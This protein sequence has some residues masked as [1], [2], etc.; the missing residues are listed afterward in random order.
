MQYLTDTPDGAWAEFL[1]HEEIRDPVDLQGVRRA[2]WAIDLAEPPTIPPALEP[3]IALG[4]PETY[5]AC[6]EAAAALRGAGEPGLVAPSAAL[7]EGAARGWRVEHGLQEAAPRD[8]H[9]F[10]LF[11]ARPEATGWLAAVGRPGEDVL[12]RVRH[13]TL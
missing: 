8:G 3:H 6:Q 11:G 4:N 7:F 1:R 10:V 9:V 2:I 13:F 12:S 5:S